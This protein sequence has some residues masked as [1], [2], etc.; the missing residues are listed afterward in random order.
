[1]TDR[2][3]TIY[4]ATAD[5]LIRAKAQLAPCGSCDAG[6]SMSCTCPEEDPRAVIADLIAEIEWLTSELPRLAG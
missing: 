2:N 4:Q 6:L 3:E 1:M 5:L